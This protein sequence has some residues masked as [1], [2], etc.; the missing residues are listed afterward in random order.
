M[1]KIYRMQQEDVVEA[2]RELMQMAYAIA[3][4]E[5]INPERDLSAETHL[6]INF[7]RINLAELLAIDPDTLTDVV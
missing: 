6:R 4:S 1:K 7:L 3:R 2:A 5:M